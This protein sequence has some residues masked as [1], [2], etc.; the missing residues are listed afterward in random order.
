VIVTFATMGTV[1]SIDVTGSADLVIDQVRLG[2][3]AL[4]NRF[5]LY[6]DDSEISRV[7]RGE[8]RLTQASDELRLVYERAVEWRSQT[9]GAFTPHR[10]DGV[11]DL[12]GIVKAIGIEQAGALLH[13]RGFEDWCVNVGGDVLSAG[14]PPDRD[15]WSIGIVDPAERTAL[16]CAVD[17][18]EGRLAIATSGTSERGEHVWRTGDDTFIQVSVVA[19]DIVTAD[20]LATAI[21]S[22]GAAF[23]DDAT[24]RWDIDVLAVSS[25]GDLRMTPGMKRMLAGD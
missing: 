22:G 8:L 14:S 3:D 5:S 11:L 17:L 16:L 18:L 2:F 13:D 6:R 25:A 12:N 7:A 21:L 4:E 20:V 1:A 15:F 19:G 10:P 24:G 23:L 9:S